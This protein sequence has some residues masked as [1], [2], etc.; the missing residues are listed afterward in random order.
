MTLDEILAD[1]EHA[2]VGHLV[3]VKAKLKAACVD[4]GHNKVIDPARTDWSRAVRV[5]AVRSCLRCSC[6][7][8]HRIQLEPTP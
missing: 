3:S 8:G 2:T 7:N 1:A 6:C 5:S 4:C